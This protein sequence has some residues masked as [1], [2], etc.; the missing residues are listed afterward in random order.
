MVVMPLSFHYSWFGAILLM[1]LIISM[2]LL[3]S[4]IQ[5]QFLQV[6]EKAY[7]Q[8]IVLAS[9]LNSIFSN[10]GIALGSAT[11]GMLVSNFGMSSVG[12]GG[13]GYTLVTFILVVWLNRLNRKFAP[14]SL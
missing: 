1:M 4:P 9:S 7:P 8:S 14:Q 3:N 11:G 5:I 6:A 10:F 13:A 2:P 12:P